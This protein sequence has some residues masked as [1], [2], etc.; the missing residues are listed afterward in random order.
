MT[1]L[2]H[3]ILKEW[4][5]YNIWSNSCNCYF[6][7]EK[8]FITFVDFTIPGKPRNAATNLPKTAQIFRTNEEQIWR[9]NIDR[10]KEAPSYKRENY[11]YSLKDNF[12][13]DIIWQCFGR[14]VRNLHNS[15]EALRGDVKQFWT[16]PFFKYIPFMGLS[17]SK[18][19]VKLISKKREITS[20]GGKN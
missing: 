15:F 4:N 9:T 11:N 16:Q 2:I 5:E 3:K 7:L 1:F 18:Y 12:F 20:L 19:K 13:S 10:K 14:W 8:T 6:T 17:V